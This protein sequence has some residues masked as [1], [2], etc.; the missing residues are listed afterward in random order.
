MREASC[1]FKISIEH[2]KIELE[3]ALIDMYAH[4]HMFQEFTSI[5]I[6]N[7]AM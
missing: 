3:E 2:V 5:I 1:N 4:L 6:N 7:I